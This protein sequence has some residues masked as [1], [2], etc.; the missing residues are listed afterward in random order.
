LRFSLAKGWRIR[1]PHAQR[2]GTPK[3]N[4]YNAPPPT[5]TNRK[6]AGMANL[7]FFAFSGY[8]RSA[9]VWY[10][11]NMKKLLVFC[12]ALVA[13]IVVMAPS[14]LSAQEVLYEGELGARHASPLDG[15]WQIIAR[16]DGTRVLV[17]GDDFRSRRGPDLKIFFS[18]MPLNR[19]RDYN[20]ADRSH[21]IRIGRLK[22]FRGA[23]EYELPDSLDLTQYRSW[24]VHCEAYRHLWDG[25]ELVNS[26]DE[27]SDEPEENE[28][29]ADN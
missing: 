1:A 4:E 14:L 25:A 3:N 18:R 15:G 17:L 29:G 7:H 8:T 9:A 12:S 26:V 13:L 21:A 11:V 6:T 10:D 20:A 19:I 16:E 23:Q 28:E 2:E 24:V 5:N 27:S 22:A